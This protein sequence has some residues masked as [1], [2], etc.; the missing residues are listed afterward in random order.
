MGQGLADQA[1]AEPAR[2]LRTQASL[3]GRKD[4]PLAFA[5][6]FQRHARTIMD[7]QQCEAGGHNAQVRATVF[8]PG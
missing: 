3:P 6:T 1:G 5:G 7:E 8:R 4:A 2:G